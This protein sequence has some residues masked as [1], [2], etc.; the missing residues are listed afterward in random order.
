MQKYQQAHILI[1]VLCLLL[2]GSMLS[3]QSLSRA[4]MAYRTNAAVLVSAN[5]FS[6]AELAL[7]GGEKQ[8]RVL[9]LQ[10]DRSNIILQQ[11]LSYF[12]EKPV[13]WWLEQSSSGIVDYPVPAAIGQARYIIEYL[14]F[15]PFQDDEVITGDVFYRVTA[16]GL[17]QR[18]FGNVLLQTTWRKRI[19]IDSTY[20]LHRL[21]WRQ[22]R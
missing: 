22:L 7:Q 15:T 10:P 9:P 2:I 14:G 4:V 3:V 20:E 11:T 17:G 1:T 8:I 19:F 13:E 18:G 21:A 16:F 6:A 5:A 12:L